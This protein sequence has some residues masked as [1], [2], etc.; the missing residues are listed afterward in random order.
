MACS[1][2][3]FDHCTLHFEQDSLK[4]SG[5]QLADLAAHYCATMLLETLGL[6]KKVVR[7]DEDPGSEYSLGSS[8]GLPFVTPSLRNRRSPRT[9]MT[10][11]LRTTT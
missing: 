4:V 6:V 5:I 10:R 9:S 8:Y 2:G 1:I 7:D 3:G 11:M